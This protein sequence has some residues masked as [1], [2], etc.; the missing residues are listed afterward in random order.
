MDVVYITLI[1]VAGLLFFIGVII[2]I[3]QNSYV[4]S[5]ENTVSISVIGDGIR[6][7]SFSR[8]SRND[9]IESLDVN[10]DCD[11]ELI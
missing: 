8:N 7:S 11:E 4:K 2:G 3:I 1:V 10:D 9:N 6:N 5:L